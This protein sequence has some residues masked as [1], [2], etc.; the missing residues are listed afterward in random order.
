MPRSM[1]SASAISLIEA[2]SSRWYWNAR[3]SALTNV[4]SARVATAG[5]PSRTGMTTVFRPGRRGKASGTRTVML[6]ASATP[7]LGSPELTGGQIGPKATFVPVTVHPV[8]MARPTSLNGSQIGSYAPISD[9]NGY[10][11]DT[12]KRTSFMQGSWSAD[13]CDGWKPEPQ[14]V[15]AAFDE[16]LDPA[17]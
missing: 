7:P 12:H 17:G 8:S 10:F 6:A 11:A 9:C 4:G 16:G 14:I 15:S 1:R 2:S 13:F 3:A 5:T